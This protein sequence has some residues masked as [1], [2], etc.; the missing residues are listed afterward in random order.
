[1]TGFICDVLISKHHSNIREMF[2]TFIFGDLQNE[3][4]Q[5]CNEKAFSKIN[6]VWSENEAMTAEIKTNMATTKKHV[7]LYSIHQE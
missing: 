6:L 1:M 3:V 2:P 5:K 7:L 4:L